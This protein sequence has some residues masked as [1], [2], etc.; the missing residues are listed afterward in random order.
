MHWFSAIMNP[1]ITT[2]FGRFSIYSKLSIDVQPKRAL[3]IG[4]VYSLRFSIVEPCLYRNVT[5]FGKEIKPKHRLNDRLA[6]FS[7][8]QHPGP[9]DRDVNSS[10]PGLIRPTAH[11][12]SNTT[13]LLCA[14]RR[15]IWSRQRFQAEW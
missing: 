3:N 10:Y 11:P 14:R 6:L 13:L 4:C 5:I 8:R 15:K 7:V 12:P 1:K 9:S 2:F